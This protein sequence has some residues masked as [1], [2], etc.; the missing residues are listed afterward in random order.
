[1]LNKKKLRPVEQRNNSV[2]GILYQQ[3]R[4]KK[5]STLKIAKEV[6][7]TKDD[8]VWIFRGKTSKQV[9]PSRVK[10]YLKDN[11]KLLKK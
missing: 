5:K 4:K 1:M 9:H 7:K 8:Y 6:E 10:F 3:H 11:W 2:G